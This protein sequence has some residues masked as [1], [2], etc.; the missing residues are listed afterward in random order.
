MSFNI[1]YRSN[2]EEISSV[3]NQILK[4]F[5]Q[6]EL[7]DDSYL[8]EVVM[9]IDE[10]TCK[11]TESLNEEVVKSRLSPLDAKRDKSARVIF[12]EIKSK[13]LWP[14]S[15]IV[16]SA[17]LIMDVLNKYGMEVINLSYSDETKCI[18]AMLEDFK[19]A[20]VR[21][22]YSRL[23]GFNTLVEQLQKD[24]EI[25]NKA[26]EEYVAKKNE[27]KNLLSASKIAALIKEQ[28]NK[29]LISYLEVMCKIKPIKFGHVF[30]QIESIILKNNKI[31]KFRVQQINESKL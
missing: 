19:D 21:K 1:N 22:A 16:D 23:H 2:V 3:A 8:L 17:Q 9:V 31:V 11:M 12:L 4:V 30:S 28:I 10:N 18:D 20:E 26:F 15:D 24:Q 5:K 13:L 25:F 27:K 6:S 7:G 14:D 29:E